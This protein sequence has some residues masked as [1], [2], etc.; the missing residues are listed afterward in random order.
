[1]SITVCMPQMPVVKGD[2]AV[3]MAAHL[4]MIARCANESADVV[5]FPEL[6]LTGYELA[7]ANS[8]AVTPHAAH[9]AELSAAAIAH[10][11]VVIAGCPLRTE[12]NKPAIG[13]VICFPDGT[14]DF[15][16]KQYLHAGE[17]EYCAAGSQDYW[18]DLKGRRVGLA[19]CADF[20]APEHALG[21]RQQGVDL[22]IV[23]ALISE[24]G[25][26]HDARVLADI[27]TTHQMPVLLSNHISETGGW[28]ASGRNTVWDGSGDMAFCSA[29]KEACLVV[30]TVSDAGVSAFQ[31]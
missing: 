5:A 21:L 30:C 4:A 17:A 27:A 23:S 12:A 7:L 14:V 29:S 15:Y 11:M 13:A 31:R 18:F 9:F 10:K 20:A 6:S 16:E 26:A 24:A 2:I 19:I 1:M 22:Y 25:F 3:N 28:V 8:L